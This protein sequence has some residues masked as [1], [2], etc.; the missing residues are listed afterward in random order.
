MVASGEDTAAASPRRN[1]CEANRPHLPRCQSRPCTVTTVFL[2]AS[3]GRKLTGRA[4]PGE[5]EEVEKK[6]AVQRQPGD[7]KLDQQSEVSIVYVESAQVI[8]GHAA[9]EFGIHSAS[10]PAGERA[11]LKHCPPRIVD[12]EACIQ[13]TALAGAVP[14]SRLQGMVAKADGHADQ[15]SHGGQQSA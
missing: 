12:R 9:R 13:R 15:Q 5:T 4:A 11:L 1:T 10:R 3:R 6:E 7:A 14:E 8:A 2:P